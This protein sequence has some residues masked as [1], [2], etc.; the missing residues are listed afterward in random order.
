MSAESC[1]LLARA[2]GP[3]RTR[4]VALRA[5]DVEVVNDDGVGAPGR[6]AAQKANRFLGVIPDPGRRVSEMGDRLEPRE[7]VRIDVSEAADRRNGVGT[8]RPAEF[9]LVHRPHLR[10]AR[11][12][13]GQQKDEELLR[14]PA[15]VERLADRVRFLGGLLRRSDLARRSR[16]TPAAL[17][18]HRQAWVCSR[19][20][21]RRRSGTS[22]RSRLPV[23]A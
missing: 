10:H 16:K 13:M 14:G 2:F 11:A 18:D 1:L 7:P 8:D 21:R 23:S 6:V 17:V 9:V 5:R 20:T 22:E 12:C 4:A 3:P 19:S 15:K